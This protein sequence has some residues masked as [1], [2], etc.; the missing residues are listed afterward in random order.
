MKEDAVGFDQ[1]AA[2]N[3]LKIISF[4]KFIRFHGIPSRLPC[5]PSSNKRR[6]GIPPNRFSVF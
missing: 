4:L 1:I 5:P 3:R 2:G 6:T